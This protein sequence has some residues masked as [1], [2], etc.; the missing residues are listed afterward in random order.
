MKTKFFVVLLSVLALASFSSQAQTSALKIGYTNI[1]VLLNGMP[2]SKQI[3]ADL[4]STQAQYEKLFQAK[5]KD[6]Q[7]KLAIFEKLPANTSEVIKADKEKE[8][9]SL[10]TQIQEFQKNSQE[11]LQKKQRQ[12]LE[13]VLT[14]I[15]GGID[16]V[17]KE[18]AFSYVFNTAAS[19]EGMPFLLFATPENDITDLVFK[20]LG[21]TPP[22]KDAA[23]PAASTPAP[24]NTQPKKN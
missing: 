21:V 13:P 1:D 3:E 17:A 12:L 7:D 4:K 5:V 2:E 11:D 19:A 8:L 18:N 24:A 15:Q 9:Q 10:Q 6:F 16:A 20:K 14:K 23:K 22:A